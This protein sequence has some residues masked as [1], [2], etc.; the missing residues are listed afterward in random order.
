MILNSIA[1]WLM[2][3]R[4]HQIELFMKYPH[5]VQ[6]E[7]MHK[8]LS[9]AAD[10]VF[11]T[12]YKLNTISTYQQYK[13]QIPLSDYNDIKPYIDRIRKGEQNVLWPTPT[14][15]FAKSSG[16][17]SDKSKFIPVTQESLEGCHYNGGRDM[18]T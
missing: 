18:V 14:T 4:M 8:L 3:K 12:K 13:E 16:T 6:Q 9:T 7:W 11:G 2:R 1:T 10:T 5:D 17:T 15:W